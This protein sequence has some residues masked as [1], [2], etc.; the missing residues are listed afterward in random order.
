VRIVQ[1][2]LVAVALGL[3]A[4]LVAVGLDYLGALKGAEAS[5]WDARQRLLAEPAKH[6]IVLVLID[7]E[8]LKY[9]IHAADYHW[10][11]PRVTYGAMTAFLEKAGAKSIAYDIMFIEPSREGDD[12]DEGLGELIADT[13][14][15]GAVLL[16]DD[17]TKGTVSWPAQRKP[18]IDVTD[19]ADGRTPKPARSSASFAN[20]ALHKFIPQ[21]GHVAAAIDSDKVIRRAA[22]LIWFD[23][24]PIPLLGL[25]DRK[26]V[27]LKGE[28]LLFGDDALPIDSVGQTYLRFRE[29]R[30]DGYMF[31]AVSAGA[32]LKAGI[33]LVNEEKVE[34][35]GA[36]F[37]DAH[38]FVGASAAALY[39]RWPT[40]MDEATPGVEVHATALDN[41]LAG[42]AIGPPKRMHVWMFT[43]A[44]AVVVAVGVTFCQAGTLLVFGAVVAV[45]VILVAGVVGFEGGLWWPVAMPGVA[46]LLSGGGSLAYAYATEGRQRRFIKSAFGH[47]LSPH[48]IDLI[49]KDPSSLKLGGVRRELSIFF[50]D[51]AG[52]SAIS[53]G[54]D[55]EPLTQ[56]LNDYLG[57]M[58]SVVLDADGTLDKYEGDAIIAF[59]N[60]PIEQDDHAARSVRSAL[61]CQQRLADE[62]DA[63]SARANAPMTMRIGVHTGLVVVG[64]MG[65]ADRFDY[66]VLGDAANLASRLEGANKAFGTDIMI[67]GVTWEQASRSDPSLIARPIGRITVVGRGEPV[68][69]YE[70]IQGDGA[71]ELAAQWQQIMEHVDA[72]RFGNAKA[73][74]ESMADDPLRQAYLKRFAE[75]ADGTR[76]E[77]DGIWRLS[78]K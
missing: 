73:L 33:A 65:S 4:T 31:Q 51:L 14:F 76:S 15:I 64:N 50:S 46:M 38:V 21:Y 25:A 27:T 10:P 26:E 9:A 45:G 19:A 55:P 13:G 78:E 34:L 6:K 16:S 48:V 32:V 54:L 23:Q 35:D 66:T 24:Q 75:L 62:R 61:R 41:L 63:L 2:F 60:A 17:K 69:V 12:D 5:A 11:W 39:D 44:V 49:L 29:R 8:A 18:L 22:P 37:K 40:P 1:K 28:R 20:P 70:P 67:S 42:D 68:P 57:E 30:D 74:L 77:W 47:Y 72:N 52:F 59:W 53:E 58:T 3:V 36:I 56:L 71:A 43:A 7:E